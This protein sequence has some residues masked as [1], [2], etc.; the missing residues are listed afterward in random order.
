[1]DTFGS[2]ESWSNAGESRQLLSPYCLSSLTLLAIP[3][4]AAMAGV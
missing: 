1:M 4:S 3:A 2:L